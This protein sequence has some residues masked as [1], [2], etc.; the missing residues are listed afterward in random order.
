MIDAVN[1]ALGECRADLSVDQIGGRRVVAQRL[2]EDHPGLSR[3][4]PGLGEVVAHHGEQIRG[5]REEKDAHDLVAAFEQPG[6]LGIVRLGSGIDLE[7]M[8]QVAEAFPAAWV[9]FLA[10]ELAAGGLR[11]GRVLGAGQ[12][13]ARDADDPRFLGDLARRIT[14]IQRG[15][16]L[17]GH[18]VARSPEEH[19]VKGR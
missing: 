10:E 19:H 18:E 3:D 1:L 13:S 17:A 4:H 6:Q 8:E 11:L 7:V 15:Q 5:R 12:R 9:E 14:A 16:K 2:L